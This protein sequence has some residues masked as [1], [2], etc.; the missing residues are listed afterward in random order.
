MMCGTKLNENDNFCTNCGS[1]KISNT[2]ITNQ[3]NMNPDTKSR[4]IAGLLGIFLG[5]FG[6][7]NFYLGN[8]GR[9]FIQLILTIITCLTGGLWGITEGVL[10]LLGYINEDA[11]GNPLE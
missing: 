8:S 9:G 1:N 2:Q 3:E 4:R 5:A 6:V 10:I 7:H 11:N